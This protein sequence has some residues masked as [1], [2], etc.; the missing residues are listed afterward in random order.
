M[1][2]YAIDAR[3]I[4]HTKSTC[5]EAVGPFISEVAGD[6]LAAAGFIVC[7]DCEPR[8]CDIEFGDHDHDDEECARLVD[9]MAGDPIPD[10]RF[11]ETDEFNQPIYP[12]DR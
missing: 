2:N 7:A 3:G 1:T 4:A 9:A 6:M 11:F 5:E 12:T 10:E 8:R